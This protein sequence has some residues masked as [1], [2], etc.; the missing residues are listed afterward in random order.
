MFILL[1][2]PMLWGF[3]YPLIRASMGEI[4]AFQFLVYRFGIAF[5][6]LVIVFRRA[7]MNLPLSVW[8]DGAVLGIALSVAYGALNLGL[9]YTTTVK[10]GFIM[11]F[12]VVLI[13]ILALT[14]LRLPISGRTWAATLISAVGVSV[15]FLSTGTDLLAINRGDAIM[16]VSALGFAGHVLLIGRLLTS[17]HMGALI[18]IQAAV[19]TIVGALFMG[20]LEGVTL[21]QS[22]LNWFHLTATGLLSTALALWLQNRYQP[23]VPSEYAGIIYSAE[24]LFAGFFGF[25]YLG[26]QLAG[27][28]WLGALLILAA[29]VLAQW[30]ELKA[31]FTTRDE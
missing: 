10:A 26:E 18:V 2:V 15:I 14:L 21:P 3:G 1:M 9:T 13:P 29:M 11:G 23:M 25:L 27:A 7:L 5:V 16:L 6:P 28:Q 22:P 19:V 31:F 30:P 20:M 8:R 4:G 17:E 12:R 24:P